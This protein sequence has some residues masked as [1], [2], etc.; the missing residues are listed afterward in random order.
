MTEKNKIYFDNISALVALI[1]TGSAT[2]NDIDE[3][4]ECAILNDKLTEAE[5]KKLLYVLLDVFSLSCC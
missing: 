4:I 1:K 3:Q 2:L 5:A